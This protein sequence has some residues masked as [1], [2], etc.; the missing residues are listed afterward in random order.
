MCGWEKWVRWLISLVCLSNALPL[1]SP[2]KKWNFPRLSHCERVHCFERLN[3]RWRQEI[4]VGTALV[5]D[6]RS[7]IGPIIDLSFHSW[8][9]LVNVFSFHGGSAF[10]KARYFTNVTKNH[11]YQI[12]NNAE[13][14]HLHCNVIRYRKDDQKIIFWLFD[15]VS[16]ER[17]QQ[18]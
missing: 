7:L 5:S 18:C 4:R 1:I 8:S 2:L 14:L 15:D 17:R 6:A 10:P 13:I 11:G 12:K 9:T 16:W 3:C